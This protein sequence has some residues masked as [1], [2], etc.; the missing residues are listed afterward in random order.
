MNGP[1]KEQPSSKAN[2]EQQALAAFNHAADE[3]RFFKGQQWHVANYALL[4]YAAV[5]AAQRLVENPFMTRFAEV[6]VVAVLLVALVALWSLE[7]A[8]AKERG[9]LFRVRKRHLPLIEQIHE[10]RTPRK[11][12]S[13]ISKRLDRFFHPSVTPDAPQPSGWRAGIAKIVEALDPFIW[14]IAAVILGA[15][16]AIILIKAGSAPRV[17]D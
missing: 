13:A 6:L 1:S 9:R 4:A 11:Y 14:L 15:I 17:A 12:R 8:L 5:V 16:L 7:D 10:D 3:L 2:E